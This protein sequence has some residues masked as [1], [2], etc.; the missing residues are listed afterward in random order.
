MQIGKYKMKAQ[1]TPVNLH[2]NSILK[3]H[4]KVQIGFQ[5]RLDIL[6]FEIYTEEVLGLLFLFTLDTSRLSFQ[7]SQV[8]ELGPP[9]HS[10][11]DHINVFDS[12]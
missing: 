3:P 1:P 2:L 7:A 5:P 10:P 8:E 6:Q 12:R 4:C 11:A 9:H